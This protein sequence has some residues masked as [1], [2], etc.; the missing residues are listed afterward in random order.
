MLRRHRVTDLWTF[1][2]E[3]LELQF[4]TNAL[5]M[6][7]LFFYQGV[8]LY[9]NYWQTEKMDGLHIPVSSADGSPSPLCLQS[10]GLLSHQQECISHLSFF[11]LW[12]RK[13][14]VFPSWERSRLMTCENILLCCIC[15]L[16]IQLQLITVVQ[17]MA[18]MLERRHESFTPISLDSHQDMVC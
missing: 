3:G 4:G 12:V 9:K 11:A 5:V 13:R 16:K 6:S 17:N 15:L 18:K 7:P 2:P 14:N 10:G 1:W 8:S